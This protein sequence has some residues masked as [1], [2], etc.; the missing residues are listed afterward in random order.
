MIHTDKET[1]KSE[2]KSHRKEHKPYGEKTKTEE[3]KREFRLNLAVKETN[4]RKEGT[5]ESTQK[6]KA[7]E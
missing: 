7:G 4:R 3:R 6:G 1:D 5:R 2:G